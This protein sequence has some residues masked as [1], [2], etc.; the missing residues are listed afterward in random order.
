[1]DLQKT[2]RSLSETAILAALGDAASAV[3]YLHALDPPVAHRD[4][5][6]ENL[7]ICSDG[8]HKL[9]DFGSCVVGPVSVRERSERVTEEE[10]IEKTTTPMYRAPEMV[11]L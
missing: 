11:K 6:L 5:K 10:R 9:C 1:M 7:L 8:P 2:D 3:A 4:V